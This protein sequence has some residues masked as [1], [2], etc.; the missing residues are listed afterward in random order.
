MRRS[1]LTLVLALF[2]LMIVTSAQG[3]ENTSKGRVLPKN[4]HITVLAE[5]LAPVR[6]TLAALLQHQHKRYLRQH[7]RRVRQHY[8]AYV[9]DA[10]RAQQSRRLAALQQDAVA[11]VGNATLSAIAACES[12]GNPRAVS[13]NGTYRGLFQFDYGTWASVGGSGDPAAAS[14]AEQYARAAALYA[15]SGSSPWPVCGR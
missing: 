7:L 6:P 2:A 12:G 15:R 11:A 9:R 10:E 5:T 1:I 14:A 8:N 13:A 3:R 4:A